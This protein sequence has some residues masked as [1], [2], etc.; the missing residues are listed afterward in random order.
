MKKTD[1]G[2]KIISLNKRITFK[3]KLYC[4]IR[5]EHNAFLGRIYFISN[6]GSQDTFVYQPHFDTLEL[7]KDKSTDSV[8]SWKSKGVFNSKL[9][10]LYT[11]FLHSINF[12]EYRIRI[13]FDKDPLVVEQSSYLTKILNVYIHKVVIKKSM[14][15]VDME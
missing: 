14:C 2:N 12:S 9:K 11:A 7:K 15:I 13:K 3:K 10:P 1:F 4:L 8:L 5:T 6:D